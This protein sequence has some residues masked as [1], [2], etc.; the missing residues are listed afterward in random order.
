MKLKQALKDFY[1][2]EVNICYADKTVKLINPS[3]IKMHEEDEG[4]ITISMD[5]TH[6]IP[7]FV[8]DILKD[9]SK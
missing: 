9:K 1:I 6:N 4:I 8:F 5:I 3:D 7:S 2:E